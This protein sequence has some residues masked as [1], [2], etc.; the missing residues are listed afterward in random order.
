MCAC[1]PNVRTPNCG[2]MA[3]LSAA[4]A[5]ARADIVAWLRSLPQDEWYPANVADAI[6]SGRAEE[7]AHKQRLAQ[8]IK[9]S[10]PGT[11]A[12]RNK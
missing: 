7:W 11:N 5:K 2:S 9:P 12:A 1:R 4:R 3:C 10:D 6:E 8:R